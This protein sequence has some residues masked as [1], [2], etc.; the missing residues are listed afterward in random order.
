MHLGLLVQYK[1]LPWESDDSEAS[2]SSHMCKLELS[3]IPQKDLKNTTN[4]GFQQRESV[5][6]YTQYLNVC[7]VE[8]AHAWSKTSWFN[9]SSTTLTK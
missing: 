5:R 7:L 1:I 6:K 8:R 3:Q 4:S 2:N 9:P